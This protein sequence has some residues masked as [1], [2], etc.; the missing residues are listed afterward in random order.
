[1]LGLKEGE[2][3]KN[4]QSGKCDYMHNMFGWEYHNTSPHFV[5]LTYAHKWPFIYWSKIH[6]VHELKEDFNKVWNETKEIIKNSYK[7]NQGNSRRYE[8]GV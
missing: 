4:A 1:L 8:R 5:K 2:I 6:L 3:R 7:W